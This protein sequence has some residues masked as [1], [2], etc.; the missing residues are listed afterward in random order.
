M[1][2][3]QWTP[4]LLGGNC[5]NRGK[6]SHRGHRGH[7]EGIKIGP[8]NQSQWTPRL[9]GGNC[10]NRGKASHKGHGG[11]NGMSVVYRRMRLL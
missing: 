8:V 4:R 9:L 3:S 7:R 11:F 10:T 2:Q 1:N 5:T 6:A